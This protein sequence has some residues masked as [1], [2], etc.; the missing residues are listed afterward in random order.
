MLCQRDTVVYSECVFNTAVSRD[1]LILAGKAEGSDCSLS[2]EFNCLWNSWNKTGNFGAEASKSHVFVC[3]LESKVYRI[4]EDDYLSCRALKQKPS[5]RF[6]FPWIELFRSRLTDERQ[7][8]SEGRAEQ[9][10]FHGWM[11]LS[12]HTYFT[13]PSPIICSYV[14]ISKALRCVI[15]R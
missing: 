13:L 15:R 4:G 8:R 3:L 1:I 11:E 14:R 6:L 2:A 7:V 12:R 5:A 9:T 10:E